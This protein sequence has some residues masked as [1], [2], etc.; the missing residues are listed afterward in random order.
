MQ[1]VRRTC[2]AQPSVYM[3]ELVSKGTTGAVMDHNALESDVVEA[4]Y[5]KNNMHMKYTS[6]SNNRSEL[7]QSMASQRPSDF[8]TIMK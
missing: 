5:K 4:M 6:S 1:E 2:E 7:L 8:E 3:S